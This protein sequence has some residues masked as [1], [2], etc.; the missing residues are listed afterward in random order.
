M[1]WVEFPK[2][3]WSL[4]KLLGSNLVGIERIKRPI[5]AISRELI[6]IHECRI[7]T[8]RKAEVWTKVWLEPEGECSVGNVVIATEELPADAQ[9]AQTT[10]EVSL[11]KVV[12]SQAVSKDVEVAKE[13][14]AETHPFWNLLAHA[15]YEPW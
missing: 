3:V 8:K 6:T 12:T 2:S 15:G 9:V 5:Q 13:V 1:G 14:A 7:M 4:I 10:S 11:I